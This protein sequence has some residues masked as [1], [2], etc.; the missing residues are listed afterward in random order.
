MEIIDGNGQSVDI[1]IN[2]I[3]AYSGTVSEGLKP[4]HYTLNVTATSP[5][6]I[7]VTQ[8]RNQQDFHL[9][10]V[11]KNGGGDALIGPFK[12]TGAYRIAATNTG[13]ANFIVNVLDTTGKSQDIPINEIG[14]YSGSVVES[15]VTPGS[16]YLQVSSN[17]TWS[18]T[19]SVL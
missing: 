15:D 2:A 9:P 4:G 8:P 16:Y 13:P 3:G 1:P 6:T 10:Y 7:T 11:F 5:W 12:A 18:I 17:G 14:N 19:V